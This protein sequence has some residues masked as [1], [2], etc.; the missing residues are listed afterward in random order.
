MNSSSLRCF[1]DATIMA[2]ERGTSM[3]CNVL[4]TVCLL[5]FLLLSQ[6]GAQS[7]PLLTDPIK[8]RE[9]ERMSNR[10][11]MTLAQQES[12]LG[13]YDTY[14]EDFAR[15]RVGAIKDFEDDLAEAA[16]TF[17]FMQFKIPER[18]MVESLIRK[19]QRAIRAIHNSDK[20]FFEEV[21][22]MLTEK[23]RIELGRIQIARELEAYK[24]FIVEMLG[25]LNKGARSQLRTM[26]N[27]L[28][29]ESNVEIDELLDTYD[30]RYLRE[31]KEG[32]DA[33]VE[34]VRLILDQIDELNVR[35]LDR[36]ALMMRFMADPDAIEDLKRRGEILLKPLVDQAYEL[37]Q[38]NW[39]TWIRLDSLLDKENAYK[40]QELYFGKS[41]RDAVRGGNN[42]HRSIDR[43]IE[44][45]SISEGQ[46]I[47]LQ[48]LRKTF[49][50]KWPNLTEKHAEVL[51]KSR[52]KQTIAMMSGDAIS[53]FE[54]QLSTL[55]DS[56][57]DYVTK[58]ESR[59]D[60]ILGK[61]IM[62]QLRNDD[63]KNQP[64]YLPSSVLAKDGA[65]SIETDGDTTEVQVVIGSTS[66]VELSEEEMQAIIA[67]AEANGGGEIIIINSGEST[68]GSHVVVGQEIDISELEIN[69]EEIEVIGEPITQKLK[70]YGSA[71]IPQP[72]APTFSERAAV[73]L[74]LDDSGVLIIEA[75]YN[76]YREKYDEAYQT[77]AR[78]SKK[79]HDD[80]T[81]SGG[82]RMRKN[83]E[84]S[85]TAADAVAT[86]DTA[87]FDDLV[88]VT[89]LHRED[90][91]VKMLENHRNRQRL[92]APD[93]PFGWRGGEGDTI[94]LVGL[95]VMS[96]D[97]DALQ[98]G[99]SQKSID[100]IRAAMHGYHE[101]VAS[102]HKQ[103][104]QATYD[105][106]HLQD[107]MWLMEEKER[108][109]AMVESVQRRWRDA[110]TNV[111]DAKRSLLLA[112]QTVMEKLL[113]DVPE[114]DFWKVRMEFV[115]KAYPDVFDKG[116]DSTS[117]L[118][119]ATAIQSLDATQKS[120]LDS[121]ITTYRYD[122][123]NLC[124]AMIENHQSNAT[125]SSSEGLMGKEDVH[126]QLRLETLRFQRKELNDRIRMRLRMVLTQDQIKN[127]PGLRPSVST[128]KEWNW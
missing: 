48:E 69:F 18:A 120:A 55:K 22:G 78:G 70:L 29:I 52:Q 20:L 30:Q 104:V 84:I 19:A 12:L 34:T 33:V 125:A 81:L 25:G 106:S 79:I 11:D 62:A 45:S 66:G 72:I 117:M 8:V 44:L 118:T 127:V 87:L 43:A 121:L 71:T 7:M 82:E 126:R 85:K 109:P 86:L 65:V 4:M 99:L 94:D 113:K 32:F 128:A 28:E 23:Q 3:K 98:V 59:I 64:S 13:V 9:V 101:Q 54:E 90:A 40:L 24:L 108:E 83:N 124:E 88:A 1:F 41:F 100:S 110:F 80:K 56:R 115:K 116:T 103:Y 75:V 112:N 58:M 60:S 17:G 96:S 122:Y 97:S 37:S 10:L 47:D 76:E 35:G 16:E 89:A 39:K 68:G 111:R 21:S 77:I 53:G 107:A 26:F 36:Q 102:Q 49:Q 42:I 92:S 119:V 114:I 51:E 105:L 61:D 93:D 46:R 50:S 123:W 38:L 74:E 57:R 67:E 95:Y 73:V 6:A 27:R 63:Q 15:V 31:V 5:F 91:N 2:L 14:L